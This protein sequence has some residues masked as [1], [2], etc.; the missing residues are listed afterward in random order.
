MRKPRTALG[1][2][3]QVASLELHPDEAA[4]QFMIAGKFEVTAGASGAAQV[5]SSDFMNMNVQFTPATGITQTVASAGAP[6]NTAL[7][8]FMF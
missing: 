4:Q 3:Q 2:S 7:D 8:K 5:Q 1:P 6:I